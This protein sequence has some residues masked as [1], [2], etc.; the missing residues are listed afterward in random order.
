MLRSAWLVVV[1]V[2][3]V[4]CSPG[5]GTLDAGADAGSGCAFVLSGAVIADGACVISAAWGQASNET[6]LFATHPLSATEKGE[7]GIYLA[8]EPAA[9]NYASA[10]KGSLA[11]YKT[12]ASWVKTAPLSF[13]LVLNQVTVRS[14][15]SD[16]KQYDLD[17]TLSFDVPAGAGSVGGSAT[18]TVSVQLSF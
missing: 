12:G 16:S 13:N 15:T 17:G 2:T 11:V 9:G 8:G 4:H 6:Y 7:Y 14:M 10:A 18:G 5:P 1:A 3:A